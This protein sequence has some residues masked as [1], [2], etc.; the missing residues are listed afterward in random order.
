[1]DFAARIPAQWKIKVLDEKYI[2]KGAFREALPESIIKRPKQPYRAPIREAFLSG[3]PNCYV[4]SMLSE[5]YL[6][7]TGYFNEKK[8][9]HLIAKFNKENITFANETQNMALVGILSTQ[10]LHHHFI[11]EFQSDA[12]KPLRPNKVVRIKDNLFD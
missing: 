2:L 12:S 11:D 4:K 5:E 1:M 9:C 8:V 3:G 7:N 10:L 6:R